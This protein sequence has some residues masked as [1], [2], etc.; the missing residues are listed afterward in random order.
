[1]TQDRV[2]PGNPVVLQRELETLRQTAYLPSRAHGC[3]LCC[4]LRELVQAIRPCLRELVWTN[5][6]YKFIAF[7]LLGPLLGLVIQ[8]LLWLSGQS[9]IADLEIAAFLLGP[10]GWFSAIVLGACWLG[11]SALEQVSLLAILAA[12]KRGRRIRVRSALRFTAAHVVAVLRLSG[13]LVAWTLVLIAPFGIV[14]AVI[15][16]QLLSSYDINFYLKERPI[17]FQ[18]AVGLGILLGLGLVG[19]LVRFYAGSFVALQLVV[20]EDVHPR[21]AL[22]LSRDRVESKRLKV[23]HWVLVWV[24][25]AFVLNFICTVFLGLVGK[26]LMP[27]VDSYLAGIITR[28]GL[29]MVVWIASSVALSVLCTTLL[30]ALLFCG[31]KRLT[32]NA[33]ERLDAIRLASDSDDAAGLLTRFRIAAGLVV[34]VPLAALIGVGVLESFKEESQVLIMAHRGASFEAPENTIA[35]IQLAIDDG[36]DWVEI[37][38]QETVDGEVV[39]LHDSD[40]MKLSG[41]P[42]KIWDAQFEQLA[43]IDIGSW[44]DPK[45]NAERTPTLEEV[46]R[47]CKGR[48]GVVIELK[49]YGHDERLEERVVEI[50]EQLQMADEVMVMSLKPDKVQIVKKLRP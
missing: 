7:C 5:L 39:V 20:F 11:I 30:S 44:F 45:F 29:M 14:A 13:R 36:A 21:D 15:Y 40:F 27:S 9:V 46:L 8:S 38:V 1:M 48:A 23:I 34:L 47:L 42:L 32:P 37:D 6:I 43:E 2:A 16:T 12:D 25:I 17:E 10:L 19:V 41:N 18:I 50:V 31:Y 28:V 22:R 3:H 4:F 33:D 35:A 24:A 26:Q 49:Y